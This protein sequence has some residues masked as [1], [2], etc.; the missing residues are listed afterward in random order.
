MAGMVIV[1][2]LIMWVVYSIVV[3]VVVGSAVL[4]GYLVLTLLGALAH[5]L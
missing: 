5:G 2:K 4:I 1:E 3:A